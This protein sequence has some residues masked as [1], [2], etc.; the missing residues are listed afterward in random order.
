MAAAITAQSQPGTARRVGTI[1]YFGYKGI[2]MAALRAAIPL[3]E[4]DPF[5]PAH[6]DEDLFRMV[7]E[8]AL[9]HKLT[10]VDKTCCD[11]AGN[12]LIYL[13]LGGTSYHPVQFH[14]APSG[15]IRLPA[16]IRHASDAADNAVGQA[17][18]SGHAE[19]DDSQGYFLPKD[20]KA[21]AKVLEYR[22]AV[23]HDEKAVYDVLS[24]SAN[25]EERSAAAEAVGYATRSEAQIQALIAASL[26]PSSDVRNASIRALAVLASAFPE[27]AAKVP[28]QPYIELLSSGAWTD[29]NK[30]SMLFERLTQSRDPKLLDQLRAQALDSLEEMARWKSPGHAWAARMILG[31]MVRMSDAEIDAAQSPEQVERIIGAVELGRK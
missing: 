20:P 21:R 7:V 3:H 2:D 30:A 15:K 16:A 12:Y 6:F 13:G 29:H 18:L 22:K 27:V 26:D 23:L 5:D 8:R 19:E 4:A 11:A 31:R 17:I 25:A 24:E 14:Q 9:G 10:D 1:D 28:V